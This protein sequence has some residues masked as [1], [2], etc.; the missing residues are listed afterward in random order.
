EQRRGER[1]VIDPADLRLILD[2]GKDA[3]P[4]F[5]EA[6]LDTNY[7]VGLTS[8]KLEEN[9]LIVGSTWHKV[10]NVLWWIV[11]PIFWMLHEWNHIYYPHQL[12]VMPKLFTLV[13]TIIKIQY[14]YQWT[15]KQQYTE[16]LKRLKSKRFSNFFHSQNSN[17]F[18]LIRWTSLLLTMLICGF[19]LNIIPTRV[20][21]KDGWSWETLFLAHDHSLKHLFSGW[22]IKSEDHC[23]KW[24]GTWSETTIPFG[25]L[26]ILLGFCVQLCDTFMLDTMLCSSL[27]LLNT[28][29][30]FPID[31]ELPYI[32]LMPHEIRSIRTGLSDMLT[33]AH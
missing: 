21:H 9:R 4:N 1:F 13:T 24:P 7:K 6:L 22:L 12:H 23:E 18:R 28:V 25:L 14:W 10:A 33:R 15:D 16:L 31:V 2:Q 19:G 5:L 26:G 30:E 32:I 27:E 11:L 8:F 20:F 29:Q 17:L 3:H